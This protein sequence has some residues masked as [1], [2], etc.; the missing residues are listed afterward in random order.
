MG[1]A[2]SKKHIWRNCNNRKTCKSCSGTHP[3]CL[4]VDKTNE[5]GTSNCTSVCSLFKDGVTD[6]S[7]I[8]PVRVRPVGQPSK[9]VLQYSVLE[10]Q[11]NVSFV[12]KNL[13]VKLDVSKS[14]IQL[15]LIT[16]QERNSLI[17]STR[18]EK[19]DVLDYNKEHVAQ[20]PMIFQIN[21]VLASAFQIP[22]PEAVRNW[23]HLKRVV[24]ELV[25][26]DPSVEISLLFG[27]NCSRI[28]RPREVV[29]GKE[30][31]PYRQKSLMVAV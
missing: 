26:Y 25:P 29:T 21:S 3:T 15:L 8:V 31:Y 17:E 28:V 23:D 16:V 24:D 19:F 4:N 12:S 11:S 22:R 1:G 14:A 30:D 20:L 7:M 13:C 2:S 10:E 18:I 27:N 6:H 9:D 5:K